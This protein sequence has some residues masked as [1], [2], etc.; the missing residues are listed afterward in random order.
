MNYR[1]IL[2]E[3]AVSGSLRPSETL[4]AMSRGTK[5]NL[6]PKVTLKRMALTIKRLSPRFL[7]RT[8]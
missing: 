5:P 6:L 3:S 7:E 2:K 8:L 1:R 4:R